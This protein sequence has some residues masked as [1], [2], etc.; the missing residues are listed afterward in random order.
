[1]GAGKQARDRIA[2]R[3]WHESAQATGGQEATHR[4]R[5]YLEEGCSC[6]RNCMPSEQRGIL[7]APERIGGLQQDALSRPSLH[8]GVVQAD[9][10]L[11]QA[12]CIT[13]SGCLL[14]V[15]CVHAW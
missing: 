15:R 14:L 10:G 8:S 4:H 13:S 3:R 5:A 11:C 7:L 1:M 12:T 6:S 9:V 2:A